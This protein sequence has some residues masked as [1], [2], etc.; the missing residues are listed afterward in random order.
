[1]KCLIRIIVTLCWT[2]IPK[3][4]YG[5][6]PGPLPPFS[7]VHLGD[8]YSAG[9]GARG[10]SGASNYVEPSGCYRSPTNWGDNAY[11]RDIIATDTRNFDI[12]YFN[13]ETS[14]E[15]ESEVVLNIPTE[16]TFS[17]VPENK[18]LSFKNHNYSISYE[19]LNKNSLKVIRKVTIPWTAIATA[20]YAEYKK[21]VENVIETEEQIVGFK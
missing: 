12:S 14:N 1:M 7:I 6:L 19:L 4:I 5:Q 20:E 13:Y 2:Q 3:V 8:S 17:E 15:Y 18:I 16:K 11:T 9:N 10:A 21:F